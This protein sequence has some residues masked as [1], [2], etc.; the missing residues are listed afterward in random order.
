MA[1]GAMAPWILA[2]LFLI[3]DSSVWADDAPPPKPP[4]AEGDVIGFGDIHLLEPY[5]P[6]KFWDNRDFFFYE[7]M[8]LEIGPT[9]IRDYSPAPP[10]YKAAP[11][12]STKGSRG[13][14]RTTASRTITAGRPFPDGRDRLYR[15]I[16]N[17]GT[18]IMW[19]FDSYH[20]GRRRWQLPSSTH[21]YW[22][23]GERAASLLRGNWRRP[24]RS[25]NRVEPQ[26]LREE[27]RRSC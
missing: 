6:K 13:S 27:W 20:V 19:N 3:A 25:R 5:L 16:P 18:K 14:A 26:N 9:P 11:A 10:A 24:S 1:R 4:F 23:R 8:Q 17:A 2:G 22:D 12:R 21:S 7:G 15:V